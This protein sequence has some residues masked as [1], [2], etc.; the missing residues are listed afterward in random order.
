MCVWCLCVSVRGRRERGGGRWKIMAP[1]Q[2]VCKQG[3]SD[4]TSSVDSAETG[5]IVL[6]LPFRTLTYKNISQADNS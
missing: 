6:A 5:L 2:S 1:L 3:L 4:G